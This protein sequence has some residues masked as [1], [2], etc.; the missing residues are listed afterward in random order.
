MEEN[1]KIE[2]IDG[3]NYAD[4]EESS[5]DIKALLAVFV[6][7]WKWFALSVLICI[8]IGVAY[9]KMADPVYEMSAKMLIRE[10]EKSSGSLA[11]QMMSNLNV[12]SFLSGA[13]PSV[14]SSNTDNEIEILQ[15][16][17]LIRDAVKDLKIYADYRI[18]KGLK[19]T[20]VYKKEPIDVELDSVSLNK[21]D[22]EYDLFYK[23]AKMEITYQN[24]IY[25][26]EGYTYD[27]EREKIEFTSSFKSFPST[28]NT[29]LGKITFTHNYGVDVKPLKDGE[30]EYVSLCPPLI[31]AKKYLKKMSVE[32]TTKKTTIVLITLKDNEYKRAEALLRQ[33]IK[34][35]N[36]YGNDDKNEIARKSEDFINGR[37][38]KITQ[39]LGMTE[40][41][42]ASYKKS[43][44]ITMPELDATAVLEMT[45][46]YNSKLL[47]AETQTTLID[48]LRKY[49]S[50]KN[51]KYQLIPSNVGL[52]D[53]SAI[54]LISQYNEAVLERNRLLRSASDIAPQVIT[55][56][57]TVDDLAKG[58]AQAL[59]QA[60]NSAKI[61]QQNIRNQY[62]QLQGRIS[63][64]PSQEKMMTEISRQQ[65]VKSGIYLMMLQKREEN[66]IEL[67]NVSDKGKMIDQPLLEGKT[68]PK[69]IIIFLVAIVL[70]LGFPMIVLYVK[71]LL[72]YKVSGVDDIQSLT[73][74]PI[75]GEVAEATG[76]GLVVH[77]NTND[78]IDEIF[79]TLRT[80]LQF[81]LKKDQKV[82]M[83]TSAMLGEGKTF[84]AANLAVSFALLG[85]K[86]AL[87]D[88][89]IRKPEIAR[90][91]GVKD[92]SNG[93]TLFL[94]SDS[95]SE[96]DLRQAL[97][98][99]NAN[100]NL[101]LLTSGPI[102][103]NPSELIGNENLD[104]IIEMLK[105]SYDY[106]ILDTAPVKV[107]T[108]ALVIGKYAD[109][110][111]DVCRMDVTPK[112][113]ISQ[114]VDLSQ[115]GKLPRLCFVVNG[116]DMSKKK[117]SMIYGIGKY[118]KSS[119]NPYG[120][121]TTT[122]SMD[123]ND[124]SIKI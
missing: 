84:T 65:A 85:K 18:Q 109:I 92:R 11:S 97:V 116:I 72:R 47:E 19:K 7:N 67:A 33:I 99:S 96:S 79:R 49:V 89:D 111:I 54:A 63:S 12:P 98:T 53:K 35:Y 106:V 113:R 82:V 80:N 83:V 4:E 23:P 73:Q 24:G 26:V 40:S 43:N 45:S 78:L 123:A 81:L 6:L 41:E 58:V 37:L 64:A 59:S 94:G 13:L 50:D 118:A 76:K 112:S 75:V 90:L 105:N 15:S 68:S 1:I 108:D 28:I 17:T 70:G 102:P 88:L 107:V 66:S 91:F 9:W 36:Q 60:Y 32:T 93:A 69:G 61:T 56:T 14:G 114:V 48:Y 46:Q 122:Y 52:E 77:E 44:K 115:A 39:E 55:A 57:N 87:V 29:P 3:F 74:L 8:C 38:A 120:N 22:S 30:T 110:C 20:L 119:M 31:V 103:P 117:N 27:K 21:W 5:F 95:V 62:S 25:S 42:L 104:A 101:D 10:D 51:N 124:K 34:R 71:S 121:G 86:V 100:K 2:N 16:R